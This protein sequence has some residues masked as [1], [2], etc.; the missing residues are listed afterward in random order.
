[1]PQCVV[2]QVA[3]M[4]APDCI[5][6]FLSDGFKVYLPALLAHFGFWLQPERCQGKGPSPAGC[7]CPSYSMPCTPCVRAHA[8]AGGGL[9]F[10]ERLPVPTPSRAP[11]CLAPGRRSRATASHTGDPVAS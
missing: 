11:R 6:L 1:M 4:L 8:L 7:R 2:R 10:K 9:V 3:Q 5:P